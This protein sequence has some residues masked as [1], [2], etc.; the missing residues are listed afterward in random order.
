[1]AKTYKHTVSMKIS[2]AGIKAFNWLKIHRMKPST[3]LRDSGE[4]GMINFYESQLK[5]K[6][7]I[8]FYGDYAYE[9]FN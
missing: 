9:W 7:Q 8:E 3:V 5:Q 4:I 1:M 6:K 2:D